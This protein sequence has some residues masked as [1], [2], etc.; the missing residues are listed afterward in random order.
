MTRI[1]ALKGKHTWIFSGLIFLTLCT[2]VMAITFGPANISNSDILHCVLADCATP[3]QE[4]VIWQIR[5]PRVLVGLVAG[6]GL[7]CAGAILQN[8]TRNPLADPYL[9][10]IISGAGLGATIATLIVPEQQM[11][12]LPLAAFLG[13]LFAV[14]IV[15]GIA[16]LLRNMNHLLLTGVAV[17]FMLGAISH[18]ILYLGDP[19][20]TNRVIFWLMGSLTRVE[21]FHFYLISA[22]VL[23]TL[24]TIFALHRQIDALL[25]GDESAASL[26]VNVDK[27]RIILLALCAAVTATIVAY[28]GGI[29]FVGLMIPHI[30]RQL[31]G[32]TTMPLIFGSALVGGCFLVWV[33]VLARS[34][35]SNVEVPIGIITSAIGS[36]FFLAIMYRNRNTG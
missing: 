13:A 9:F 3:T 18:F 25:L 15:F 30:V 27:L 14:V 33:D 2:L 21:M 32:V 29:G 20:A 17:S 26:G 12:A 34:A 5:I 24:I 22:M 23:L 16:T 11:L 8:V 19:F 28:C 1:S 36:I 4:M 6:M 31:V 35:L 10:G 7:A